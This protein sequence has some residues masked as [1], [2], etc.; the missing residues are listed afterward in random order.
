MR[1]DD[2][3]DGMEAES[4]AVALVGSFGHGK[5]SLLQRLL[6]ETGTVPGRVRTDRREYTFIGVPEPVA[7]LRDLMSGAARADAAV[8]LIDATEGPLQ[9]LPHSY[10]CV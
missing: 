9:T 5:S 6:Y 4:L 2:A 10:C 8:L 7:F 3:L 1:A